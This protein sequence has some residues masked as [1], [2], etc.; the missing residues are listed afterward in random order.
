MRYETRKSQRGAPRRSQTLQSIPSTQH[1][2][3]TNNTE[4]PHQTGVHHKSPKTPNSIFKIL[5]TNKSIP[6]IKFNRIQTNPWLILTN[7]KNKQ[8]AYTHID[9]MVRTLCYPDFL[10]K[11]I[12]SPNPD[13]ITFKEQIQAIEAS[14]YFEYNITHDILRDLYSTAR[15]EGIKIFPLSQNRLSANTG[16]IF[17]R[18][19]YPESPIQS[20]NIHYH[21]NFESH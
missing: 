16:Y 7:L 12:P 3:T 13:C 2:H 6:L 1:N 10:R 18:Y 4:L 11:R 15:D 21:H 8:L 9:Q 5:S 20:I 14:F 19:Q 17:L